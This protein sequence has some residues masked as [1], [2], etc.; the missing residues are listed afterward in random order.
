MM[1]GNKNRR[2][3]TRV[4]IGGLHL[5][6]FCFPA[7]VHPS[8]LKQ[9]W[10][11]GLMSFSFNGL[12]LR[13]DQ[14]VGRSCGPRSHSPWWLQEDL[15]ETFDGTGSVVWDGSIYLCE[16]LGRGGSG[17]LDPSGLT[18]VEIG[19]GT[20]MLG[21]LCWLSGAKRVIVCDVAEQLPLL[22]HNVVLNGIEPCKGLS[23]TREEEKRCLHVKKCEWGVEEDCAEIVREG[24]IDLILAA[25]VVYGQPR[26]VLMKLLNSL[27][28]LTSHKGGR[29]MMTWKERRGPGHEN[30]ELEK[31]DMWFFNECRK[32]FDLKEQR[33]SGKDEE[34]KLIEMTT[35][36]SEFHVL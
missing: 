27:R 18:I 20:G 7:G 2:E 30:G 3:R 23:C 19:S 17:G 8:H 33:I 13:I 11:E 24:R 35:R 21:I 22:Q 34:V 5:L 10:N 14:K 6:V 12:S 26:S 16:L 32:W 1:S 15:Q 31:E 4:A 28:W 25:D 9:R 29:I 36:T